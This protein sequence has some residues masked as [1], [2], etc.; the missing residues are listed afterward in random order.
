[1]GDSIDVEAEKANLLKELD[2]TK[3]FLAGV[4]KKLSN[5]R[6]VA[7][8]PAQVLDMER[9]KQAD[10]EAKIKALEASLAQLG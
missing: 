2:Y 1:M 6:F 10:A 8:A 5:E 7:G 4:L 3:G 9:K